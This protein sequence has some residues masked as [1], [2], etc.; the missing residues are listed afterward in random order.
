M[1]I[2][3]LI[4]LVATS[5]SVQA[6]ELLDRCRPMAGLGSPRYDGLRTGLAELTAIVSLD[7][8]TL[9]RT[10][11]Y[12][13]T[14]TPPG[15][16]VLGSDVCGWRLHALTD[17]LLFTEVQ[18]V[19][20][21]WVVR[22]ARVDREGRTVV[23][24]TEILTADSLERVSVAARGEL[25]G[26]A[27]STAGF[28]PDSHDVFFTPVDL[29]TLK[30]TL[31][32]AARR[33]Q[34]DVASAVNIDVDLETT[35]ATFGLLWTA[36]VGNGSGVVWTLLEPNGSKLY[37]LEPIELDLDEPDYQDPTMRVLS[38]TRAHYVIELRV[39]SGPMLDWEWTG[40]ALVAETGVVVA[41]GFSCPPGE[42]RL[43]VSAND[44]WTHV[45]VEEDMLG[46]G[47]LWSAELTYADGIS[48]YGTEY[49]YSAFGYGDGLT[50]DC[51]DPFVGPFRYV[52]DRASGGVFVDCP[53]R[54]GVA[55]QVLRG[56]LPDR[57][58]GTS[59]G[60]RRACGV[61]DPGHDPTPGLTIYQ[62]AP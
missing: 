37:G 18:A 12:R 34:A 49:F 17:G 48:M 56:H 26:V 43:W 41:T 33:L 9:R 21:G 38:A 50:Y 1:R 25:F 59:L 22:A 19:S 29:A 11:L 35:G 8:L 14:I 52:R 54:S 10:D 5:G 36:D 7:P 27:W 6:A 23:P 3:G 13:Q 57:S 20:G 42:N 40:A 16:L 24:C 58:D 4:V 15:D 45:A 47:S 53:N 30:P 32:P 62:P 31:I 55:F 51:T 39:T 61:I 28:T 60:Y 44:D 46:F 2:V